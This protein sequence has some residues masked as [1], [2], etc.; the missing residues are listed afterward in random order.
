MDYNRWLIYSIQQFIIRIIK[1][2]K[3]FF[4]PSPHGKKPLLKTETL[5]L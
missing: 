5:Q 3:P 1:F 2:Y 4:Q